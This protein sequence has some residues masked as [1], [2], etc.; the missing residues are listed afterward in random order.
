MESDEY[1]AWKTEGFSRE[2]TKVWSLERRVH[3]KRGRWTN[4]SFTPAEAAA[5]RDAAV[6]LAWVLDETAGKNPIAALTFL[7]AEE[8]ASLGFAPASARAWTDAGFRPFSDRQWHNG[9]VIWRKHGF[10][11]REAAEWDADG[12]EAPEVPEWRKV[13]GAWKAAGFA[14][15]DGVKWWR[16]DFDPEVAAEWRD[17]GLGS[18][19][20][21]MCAKKGWSPAKARYRWNEYGFGCF[22]SRYAGEPMSAAR[23]PEDC[24]P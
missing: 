8:W 12:I 21:W 11:P 24:D 4:V 2:D 10:T 6:G 15:K 20:S 5:W 13:E 7:W 16:L 14:P 19:F 22:E 1:E 17:A 9:A 18:G 3:W 23:T